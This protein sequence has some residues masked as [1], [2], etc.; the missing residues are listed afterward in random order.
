MFDLCFLNGFDVDTLNMLTFTWVVVAFH[1]CS[2]R[3]FQYFQRNINAFGLLNSELAIFP[4]VCVCV[5]V[6][7]GG[8]KI[9]T[10]A[11]VFV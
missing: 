4:K 2:F 6:G 3:E 8:L 5:C 1:G 11:Q 10:F 9:L 7:V